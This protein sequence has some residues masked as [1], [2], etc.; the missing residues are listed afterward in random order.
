MDMTGWEFV[1]ARRGLPNDGLTDVERKRKQRRATQKTLSKAARVN[2]RAIDQ[3]RGRTPVATRFCAAYVS[4][5][6][7]RQTPWYLN[8][9]HAHTAL[10]LMQAKYG[11]TFGGVWMD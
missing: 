11:N 1:P 7:R 10:R 4:G 9:E 5:K 3:W 8:R 2:D 6:Q